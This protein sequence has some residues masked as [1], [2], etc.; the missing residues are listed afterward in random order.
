[1][2]IDLLHRFFDT[3]ILCKDSFHSKFFQLN[4]R[5]SE[6]NPRKMVRCCH[7]E[8]REEEKVEK[9]EKRREEGGGR[10]GGGEAIPFL[11]FGHPE[12]LFHEI[13]G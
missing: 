3:A 1:M 11:G 6:P 8:K 13:D 10:E 2:G 7:E 5:H 9:E 12:A 4:P